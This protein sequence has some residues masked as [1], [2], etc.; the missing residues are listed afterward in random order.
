VSGPLIIIA[1]GARKGYANRAENSEDK[2][3]RYINTYMNVYF[4]SLYII[5]ICFCL[6]SSVGATG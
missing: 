5:D 2:E 3:S 6:E 1:G 4:I